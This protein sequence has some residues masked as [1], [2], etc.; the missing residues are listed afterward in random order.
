MVFDKWYGLVSN[1]RH[2]KVKTFLLRYYGIDFALIKRYH[3]FWS[4]AYL[5]SFHSIYKLFLF[6]S[7]SMI[8]TSFWSHKDKTYPFNHI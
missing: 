2:G 3:Q 4:Q 6:V 1:E 7:L 8:V 5:F